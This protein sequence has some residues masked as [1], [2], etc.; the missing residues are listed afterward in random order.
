MCS[1]RSTSADLDYL[2][3]FEQKM[4]FDFTHLC[5][6]ESIIHPIHSTFIVNLL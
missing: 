4:H 3:L 2:L 1:G 6:H 5:I